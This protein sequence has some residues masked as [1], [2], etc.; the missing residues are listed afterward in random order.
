MCSSGNLSGPIRRIHPR[1]K[2]FTGCFVMTCSQIPSRAW[3]ATLA[4]GCLGLVA[5]G[6]ELQRTVP[7]GAVPALYLSA[8]ALPDDRWAGLARL[9]PAGG[10]QAWGGLLAALA[11]SARALPLTRAGCRRF[12]KWR[13][14]A[15]MPIR[16]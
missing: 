3:F 9:P 6:L 5:I 12:R 7:P 14:S 10:R 16:T 4:L 13:R 11:C 1:L 2:N 8:P 15:A